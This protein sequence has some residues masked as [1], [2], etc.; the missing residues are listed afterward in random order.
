MDDDKSAELAQLWE[1]AVSDYNNKS[2][3]PSAGRWKTMVA[4]DVDLNKLVEEYERDFSRFRNSHAKFWGVFKT[5]M[6]Q[7]RKLGKVAEAGIGLTPFAPATVILQAGLFLVDCGSAVTDTYDSLED[8]FKRIRDIADRLDEYSSQGA[9]DHKLRKV[10]T[11]LLCTVL[12]VFGEVETA[13]KRGRGKEMMRRVVG[14]ENKIQSALDQLDDMVRSEMNLITAK[15]Y[16]TTRRMDEEAEAERS[17]DRLQRLLCTTAAADNEVFHAG[18]DSTRIKNSAGWIREEK[19]FENWIE[20]EFPVLWILGKPGTGKTYLASWV[21]QHLRKER[22]GS[23]VTC[24]FYIREGMNTQH[25]PEVILKTIANQI[26]ESY[27][28]YR[29]I[30]VAICK[31]P[32]SLYGPE[33]IWDS[34]FVKPF[35]TDLVAARPLFVVIDGVDEATPENQELLVKMAKNLSDLRLKSRKLPA[36]QLLLL[37]RPDLDYNVSK[38]WRGERRRPNIIYVQPSSTSADVQ[39][40]IRQRVDEGIALLKKLR[41]RDAKRLRREIITRMS[42]SSEGMFMLAKL[43][44]TEI[45]DMNKPELILKALER[46]PQG[47]EDMFKRV[48]TRLMVVGGFDKDDLNEMIMW[49]A[50][51]KRDLLLGELDLVLKLRDLEQNGIVGLEEELRTRFGSFFSVAN[52]DTNLVANEEEDGISAIDGVGEW[53]VADD[54]DSTQ[55][56]DID[57]VDTTDDDEA[58][59]GSGLESED[60][61]NEDDEDDNVPPEFHVATVKF[62]HASVGQ[63]FRTAAFHEGIGLDINL[64]HAHIALTCLLFLTGN[65]PKRNKRPWR[66]P[67]LLEY[68]AD[69]FLDHLIEVN[70]E[71]LKSLH[72]TKFSELSFEISVLFRDPA[73]HPRWLRSVSDRAKFLCQLFDQNMLSRLQE[74]VPGPW[75]GAEDASEYLF[76]PFA[77]SLTKRWLLYIFDGFLLDGVW[78]VLFLHGYMS[79]RRHPLQQWT[80]PPNRPLEHIAESI[81]PEE[82][83]QMIS[84]CGLEMN[85]SAH[86]QLGYTLKRIKTR[87]HLDAALEEFR[88]LYAPGQSNSLRYEQSGREA[89]AWALFE[90]EQY[91]EAISSASRAL[92]LCTSYQAEVKLGLLSLITQ[93]NLNL[94]NHEPAIAASTVAWESMPYASQQALRSLICAHHETGRFNATVELIRP[95]LSQENPRLTAGFLGSLMM[96]WGH[97]AEFI[98]IACAKTGELELA[99]DVYM[100][101]AAHSSAVGDGSKRAK[102]NAALA[103]LYFGFYRDEQTA[104]E[105]WESIVKDDPGTW[106]AVDASFALAA[107]YFTKATNTEAEAN[108][109]RSW[110]SKLEELLSR[111]E[112]LDLSTRRSVQRRIPT[113]IISALLGRWYAERGEVEL[114]RAKIVPLVRLAIRDLTDRDNSNDLDAYSH[115]AQALLNFGDR[116]NGEIAYALT[117]P[118]QKSKELIDLEKNLG[119]SFNP[120]RSASDRE[121]LAKDE[122]ATGPVEPFNFVGCCDGWCGRQ[123]VEYRSFSICEVCVDIEFCDV[124][125]QKQKEGKLLFRVCDPQHPFIEVYPPRGL[126]SRGPDGYMVRTQD[127]QSISVHDWLDGIS[128][129]WSITT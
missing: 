116:K 65:I 105:M 23:G 58:A 13:I 127:G 114:A 82:I 55:W 120:E 12:D 24:Y 79:T 83:R 10:I 53:A 98:S 125:L 14:R 11:K 88:Q 122:T 118:L 41:P 96:D 74:Y 31:D 28:A 50:C 17:Q 87:R 101:V 103:M 46:P 56:N 67:D 62:G 113:E 108:A 20:M 72:P 38:T 84:Q 22:A 89:E 39:R 100:A 76:G 26:T 93:A 25:T 16:A 19:L 54:S 21:I 75:A 90:L 92:E 61:E 4:P 52:P 97:T 111:W 6:T 119:I 5:T 69:H 57:S 85:R 47:L 43:M 94:G 126:V 78:V 33:S 106:G 27:D 81:P 123:D 15:T 109:S 48:I 128:R 102:A 121:P 91:E 49:V 37:G 42:D 30:A 8:L 124:C 7:L 60:E 35:R 63:Y 36:I 18:V 59:G 34:L 9:I 51:A 77:Q 45:K 110:V 99:R 71:A 64:A 117:K 73:C 80:L 86:L 68:S 29:N 129:E 112:S 95:I 40:F 107:L 70:P 1:E 32:K 2:N 3:R 104:I 44:L 66:E 115:L